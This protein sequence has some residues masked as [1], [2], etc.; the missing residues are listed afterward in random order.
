MG[1]DI[2][3]PELEEYEVPY[4][5]KIMGLKDYYLEL[6]KFSSRKFPQ[7]GDE[8]A[9]VSEELKL[10]LKSLGWKIQPYQVINLSYFVLALSAIVLVIINVLAILLTKDI[11]PIIIISSIAA[12]FLL[13]YFVTEYPKSEAHLERIEA[14]SNAPS[15]LTQMVIYLKQNPNLEK[16]VEFVSKYSEGKIVDDLKNAL[17]ESLMGHKV[18]IKIELGKIAQKWGD[19]LVELKR[20]IYLIRAAV[21]EK[22]EIKRNHTLDHAINIALEGVMSK[23]Q[24]YTNKLYLPTLFLFSFGTVLP[25]V[26]ISLLPIFSFIGKEVSSPIQ[27]FLLLTFSLIAIYIYSGRIIVQ[28]PPAFSNI[29]L[30]EFVPGY[31]K[32]S[33]LRFKFG[34]INF[35]FNAFYYTIAVFLVIAFPGIIFMTG[36]IPGLQLAQNPFSQLLKGFNTL[37]IIWAFGIAVTLYAYGSSWYKQELRQKVENLEKEMID[38]TYQLASRISE[39]R[40]PEDTIKHISE[41]MPGTSFGTLMAST[42]DVIKSRHSTIEE[43]F[44]NP[45]YGSLRKVYSKNL[46]LIMRLFVNSL[47]RGIEHSSQMLFTISNHF[48][49]LKKTEEKMKETLKNSLSM[50]RMTASVFA[51]MITGLVITLQQLIQ[52]G[53]ASAKEKLGSLG[54]EYFNLSFLNPPALSV[55]MLQLV[56]GIYMLLLAVLLIRYVCLLEFGKDDVMLKSELAKNL[57]IALF[58]FTAT[59][60][61]SRIMLS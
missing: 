42:Y 44:F 18:S 12:P 56:A 20:S 38:G 41:S 14:L 13:G 61:F 53:M 33:D 26:I 23:I 40:S 21:S 7:L 45:N 28:R 46:L 43:A 1:T 15:I 9:K 50:M 60:I 49:Q 17:W 24:E 48:D 27:M 37:T 6:A 32:P 25:L 2:T 8:T 5:Q 57:P 29:K 30:P 39:G 54:Y 34:K 16:A 55:E 11:S 31:P 36:Q 19:E 58:I 4:S 10:S 3:V 51:P 47:K 22:N 35:E 52:E 59:L